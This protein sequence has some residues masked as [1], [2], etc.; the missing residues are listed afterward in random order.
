M[1]NKLLKN[2]L[3]LF[4][5]TLVSGFLLAF[6]YQITKD[7]IEQAKEQ[8]KNDAYVRV[9]KAEEYVEPDNISALIEQANK[10]FADGKHNENGINYNVTCVDEAL[11]AK[12]K[13]GLTIGY[14]VT[15]TSNRGYGGAIQVT[16]GL[17][18]DFTITGF[19][20]LSQSETAG[21]GARCVES[22]YKDTFVGDKNVNDVDILSGATYTTTAI[23]ETV[24]CGLCFVTE[25]IDKEGI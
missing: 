15:V 17:D 22:V 7:P 24:G 10:D 25:Y 14:I 4:A 19:E 3:I 13:N 21:F 12:D 1:K 9:L 5:I 6:V 11:E 23:K 18:T 8:E 2:A 20:V 16:F